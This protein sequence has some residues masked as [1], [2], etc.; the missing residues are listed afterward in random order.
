MAKQ[1]TRALMQK[2]ASDDAFRAQVQKDPVAAFAAQGVKLDP[3]Q[4]PPGGVK[5]P[6]KDALQT[7]L[8]RHA[9]TLE[10]AM[11]GIVIFIA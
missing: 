2:L 11:G 5:L 9:D 6:S 8:D 4:V 7:N 1:D 3:K 10:A